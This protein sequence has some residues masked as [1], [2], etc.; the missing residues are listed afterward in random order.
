MSFWPNT[1]PHS[2]HGDEALTADAMVNEERFA[3]PAVIA[4]TTTAAAAGGTCAGGS[5]RGNAT[6]DGSGGAPEERGLASEN[7]VISGSCSPCSPR[8][9]HSTSKRGSRLDA[10]GRATGNGAS[11]RRRGSSSDLHTRAINPRRSQ[12]L[13]QRSR[14]Q[15]SGRR[16][17]T[18]PTQPQQTVPCSSAVADPL[19][20]CAGL[21][22]QASI[23]CLGSEDYAYLQECELVYNRLF[24]ECHWRESV[25]SAM[26]CH[27][28]SGAGA[29]PPAKRP[30][31]AWS[32]ASAAVAAGSLTV[33]TARPTTS[34]SAAGTGGAR[35]SKV[36]ALPT[37]CPPPR[38]THEF[39]T[40]LSGSGPLRFS[41]A[42]ESGNLC[43]AWRA[44]PSTE[45]AGVSAVYELI[46]QPDTLSRGHAQ[47]FFF[48]AALVEDWDAGGHSSESAAVSSRGVQAPRPPCASAM[49]IR[50]R[51]LN[52]RST[53]SLF[54]SGLAPAVWDPSGQR[55]RYDLCWDVQFKPGPLLKP[56]RAGDTEPR[57]SHYML[58]FSYLFRPEDGIVFFAYCEPY[59]LSFLR[60]CFAQLEANPRRRRLLSRYVLTTSRGGN[61]VE[62][63]EVTEPEGGDSAA[64]VGNLRAT[65]PV[66]NK[67][68]E[69]LDPA[70]VAALRRPVVLVLARQ[71]PGECQGSWMAHGLLD[72]LTDPDDERAQELRRRYSFHIVPMFNV[73]GVILGNSRCSAIGLDPNRQWSDSLEGCQQ[74]EVRALKLH[75]A[76]LPLGCYMCLDLH[77]H[78]TK[79]GIFF[80]GCRYNSDRW[81]RGLPND[82]P[83]EDLQFLP[84]LAARNSELV[85]WSHC[86]A[87]MADAK[88]ATARYVLFADMG[89][90]WVYTVEAS[91]HASLVMTDVAFSSCGT[92]APSDETSNALG[93]GGREGATSGRVRGAAGAAVSLREEVEGEYVGPSG[94]GEAPVLPTSRPCGT[95]SCGTVDVGSTGGTCAGGRAGGTYGGVASGSDS[96]RIADAA[97]T[98]SCGELVLLT[99]LELAG[100][101]RALGGAILELSD[102]D[103]TPCT[104]K[105]RVQLEAQL[106][107][108][109]ATPGPFP[110]ALS[111]RIFARSFAQ[112]EDDSG[113]GS[114]ACPSDDN[115][116]SEERQGQ[117]ASHESLTSL[118]ALQQPPPCGDADGSSPRMAQQR[119]ASRRSQVSASGHRLRGP[120]T[121]RTSKA[122]FGVINSCYI[123]DCGDENTRLPHSWARPPPAVAHQSPG[124]GA[125]AAAAVAAARGTRAPSV[126]GSSS[127]LVGGINNV[128]D[129]FAQ[130]CSEALHDRERERDL[131][132]ERERERETLLAALEDD[133]LR[134][135][136]PVGVASQASRH[137]ELVLRGRESRPL[138]PLARGP[139]ERQGGIGDLLS[140]AS[141][142]L[143]PPCAAPSFYG[144][145]RGSPS[146]QPSSSSARQPTR[147][148][149]GLQRPPPGWQERHDARVGP[150]EWA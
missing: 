36:G 111:H 54:S 57:E 133:P 144:P 146:T 109:V 114:D 13:S 3:P 77:G 134:V 116:D 6:S 90:R 117:L 62:L 63:V 46:M 9:Q 42:F 20:W 59:T 82:A 44:G 26:E 136:I 96:R 87:S 83:S 95:A 35:I 48:A 14:P 100:F 60:S 70:N 27:A 28:P 25:R 147:A 53:R 126:M 81:Y 18:T 84:A 85:S 141:G 143:S 121:A 8:S 79:R 5:A 39:P 65:A 148:A 102:I 94:T 104:D 30:G 127:P 139:S 122:S 10:D 118:D 150:P 112:E 61:P 149:V 55:W 80:Y 129:A 93:L 45:I 64:P 50:L 88:R 135:P 125:W 1:L 120:T 49:A 101:G 75:L 74:P 89:I 32:S 31:Q 47:W 131:E 58:S 86:R 78:S 69:R 99:G 21:A 56:R 76:R 123:L 67:R 43:S 105:R 72:F 124:Y 106:T 115:L 66:T 33:P 4:V 34:G 137:G 38:L 15:D 103:S 7:A 132:R 16:P 107:L 145:S 128:P 19:D 140:R 11:R 23:L 12:K 98:A 97:A 110:G 71:H 51:L 113:A 24:D 22:R 52:F 2:R 108:S 68:F 40:P 37:Q 41:S 130:H 73:D 138:P 119:P 92:D 91:V 17:A 142:W 29:S